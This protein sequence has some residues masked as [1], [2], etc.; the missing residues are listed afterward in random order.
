MPDKKGFITIEYI[1][2]FVIMMIL[3]LILS[4]IIKN[5]VVY[6]KNEEIKIYQGIETLKKNLIKYRYADTIKNNELTFDNG[7]RKIRVDKKQ[8]YETPGYMPFLQNIEKVR[9]TYN[10][11]EIILKFIYKNK[12]FSAVIFY[13]K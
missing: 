10:K 5:N 9:F 2:Y 13:D 7:S 1:M 6:Q 12:E 11:N 3:C 8:I 4:L